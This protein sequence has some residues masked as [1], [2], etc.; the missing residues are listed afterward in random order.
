MGFIDRVKAGISRPGSMA[1][2]EV[3]VNKLKMHITANKQK[4]IEKH[5]QEIGRMFFL[6]A[7]NRIAEGVEGDYQF[8]ID[9]IVQLE[10]E[11]EEIMRQIKSLGK[12]KD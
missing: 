7:G 6:A 9:K 3:E 10:S 5:Y 11:M 2:T 8:H 4:E 1:R 12:E